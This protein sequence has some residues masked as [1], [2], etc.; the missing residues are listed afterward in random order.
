MLKRLESSNNVNVKRNI[1]RSRTVSYFSILN[2]HKKSICYYCNIKKLSFYVFGLIE[3]NDILNNKY[4]CNGCI[5][6]D[7]FNDLSLFF[8]TKEKKENKEVLIVLNNIFV[9]DLSNIILQYRPFYV[10]DSF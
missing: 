4:I 1:K 2:R 10:N 8:D 7:M 3:N 6:Q 9:K 5:H